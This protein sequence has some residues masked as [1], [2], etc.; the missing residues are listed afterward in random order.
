MDPPPAKRR[1]LDPVPEQEPI[2]YILPTPIQ[3]IVLECC[4][5]VHYTNN[6]CVINGVDLFNGDGLNSES[7]YC[8]LL[9]ATSRTSQIRAW[10]ID[11][12]AYWCC[13]GYLDIAR[14]V[15]MV[16][17]RSCEKAST[18]HTL[19]MACRGGHLEVVRWLHARFQLTA[20]DV[21]ANIHQGD[22][23]LSQACRFSANIPTLQY[24]LKDMGAIDKLSV[25][26][27]QMLIRMASIFGE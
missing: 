14:T 7:D 20:G 25:E 27:E 22:D 2:S 15:D 24:L 13:H 26:Q 16:C 10:F 21:L 9:L 17:P 18:D 4:V 3:S 19:W 11:Q 8:W 6:A 12:F 23:P 1:R 5:C